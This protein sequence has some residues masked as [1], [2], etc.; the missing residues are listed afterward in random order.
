MKLYVLHIAV[1]RAGA[2]YDPAIVRVQGR[3][4]GGLETPAALCGAP[5]LR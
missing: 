2:V 5:R 4:G 3:K 1:E